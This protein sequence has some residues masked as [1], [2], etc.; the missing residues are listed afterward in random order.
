MGKLTKHNFKSFLKETYPNIPDI[1]IILIYNL[2]SLQNRRYHNLNHII[3]LLNLFQSKYQDKFNSN[4]KFIITS[5]IIFHDII[6]EI[7][8]KSKEVYFSAKFVENLSY[9]CSDINSSSLNA[10]MEIII[11]TEH[12]ELKSKSN[13]SALVRDMDIYVGLG[14]NDFMK[15]FINIQK[16]YYYVPVQ[17]FYEKRITF[18]KDLLERDNIYLSAYFKSKE[19]SLRQRINI[20]LNWIEEKIKQM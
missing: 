6:Q 2:Y 19:A 8:I 14:T 12:K 18:L 13:L 1:D 16:E 10:I 3:E 11:D 4:E 5:A 17:E 15:K 20:Q 7:N 9:R